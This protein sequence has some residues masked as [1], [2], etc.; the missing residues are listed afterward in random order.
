MGSALRGSS[1]MSAYVCV[2]PIGSGLPDQGEMLKLCGHAQVIS[3]SGVGLVSGIAHIS[4][5]CDRLVSHFGL[6][7]V[8]E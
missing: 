4:C 6:L 5:A 2:F 1:P 7:L 3:E 8:Y